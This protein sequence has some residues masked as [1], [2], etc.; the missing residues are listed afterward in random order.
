MSDFMGAV[1][2]RSHLVP[3]FSVVSP[4]GFARWGFLR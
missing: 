1:V 2:G 4:A 3:D